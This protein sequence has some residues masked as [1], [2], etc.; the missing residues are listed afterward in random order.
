MT[1]NHSENGEC[2]RPVFNTTSIGDNTNT[3]DINT[4][5]VIRF[6]HTMQT[7]DVTT[8]DVLNAL[9]NMKTNKCPL[10]DNIYPKFFK[11]PRMLTALHL[12]EQ[13]TSLNTGR[14]EQSQYHPN[15]K[16]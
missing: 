10:P 7:F 3:N 6:A 9:I 1:S 8:E 2:F 4:N 5:D 11:E 12:N 16:E 14:Q 15:L 13:I